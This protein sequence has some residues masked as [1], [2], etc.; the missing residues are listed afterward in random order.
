MLNMLRKAN[1][2]DAPAIAR[3]HRHVVRKC[4]PYL[5]DLHTAEEDLAFFS[6]VFLPQHEVWV[7]DE[8]SIRGYCGFR[9]GWVGHLYV[10]PNCQKQGI[11]TALL[12]QAKAAHASLQLWVFQRNTSAI[13]FYERHGFRLLRTTDGLGNEEREPDALYGWTRTEADQN[14]H[15]SPSA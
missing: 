4:L 2:K 10:D 14:V 15:A 1:G 11:G 3:L 7:W 9:D 12:N 8:G 5:P 13:A 6:D